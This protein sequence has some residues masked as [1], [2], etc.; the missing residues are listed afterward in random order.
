[1]GSILRDGPESTRRNRVAVASET[2]STAGLPG[3]Y[4]TALYDLAH[5]AGSLDQVASDLARLRALIESSPEARQVIRSPL[6]PRAQQSKM[7]DAVLDA[8]GLCDL[9]RRFVG[10]VV[11]NRRLAQLPVFIDSFESLLARRRG[12]L[13][14]EVVSAVPLTQAQRNAISGAIPGATGRKVRL[15]EKVDPRLVGG[16]RVKVGSRLVDSSISA[17]LSRLQLAMKGTA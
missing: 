8:A 4:A 6:I 7:M 16:L 10:V 5:D 1:M 15:V 17:K 2:S 9:A 11:R 13:E 14:A 3:R 12:D